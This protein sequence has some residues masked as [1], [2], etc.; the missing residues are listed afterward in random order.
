MQ[1]MKE[2][3]SPKI[4]LKKRNDLHL[5]R[6]ILHAA[7]VGFIIGL[8]HTLSREQALI[9]ST[10]AFFLF[11]PID[12]LRAYWKP[13]NQ[14]FLKTFGRYMRDN[15]R[16]G[17]TGTSY[18]LVA[19]L[20]LI[21]FF[22]KIITS[23]ALAMLAVGDP[24]ASIVGVMYGK[25]KLVGNKSLQGSMAAFFACFIISFAYFFYFNI[26]TDRLLLVSILC[27][28]IGAASELIP[29]GKCDDNLSFPVLAAIGLLVVFYVFGGFY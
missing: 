25:D 22:P 15:E 24:I 13:A 23:L 17:L 1:V 18:L 4:E 21:A 7:G 28:V 3:F 2:T 20:L 5:S 26:M 27:G 19:V 14:I 12:W 10:I 9:A 6:K 16:H 11:V 29:V 8:F